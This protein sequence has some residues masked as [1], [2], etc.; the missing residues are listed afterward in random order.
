MRAHV[1][2]LVHNDAGWVY[3]EDAKSKEKHTC[4]TVLRTKKAF[5]KPIVPP[6]ESVYCSCLQLVVGVSSCHSDY[7]A[8]VT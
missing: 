5:Q 1:D 7:S 6:L 8:S 4:N 2:A 3:M